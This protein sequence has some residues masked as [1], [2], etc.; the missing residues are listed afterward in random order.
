MEKK[1]FYKKAAII[2]LAVVISFFA[3]ASSL[4]FCLDFPQRYS[5]IDSD[6]RLSWL[7]KRLSSLPSPQEMIGSN[8]IEFIG[9]WGLVTYSMAS[10]ALTNIAM[11]ESERAMEYS[12]HIARWIEWSLLPSAYQFDEEAWGESPLS[13]IVLEGDEG[14]IGYY[15]HL[16]FILGCYALLNDD[17]RF[18]AIHYRISEA[19]ARRMK[20]Y[21]HRHVETYPSQNYPPDNSVAVASLRFYDMVANTSKYSSLIEEWIQETKKIEAGPYGLVVFQIDTATGMPVQKAR[22][23][24]NAWNSFYLAFIDEDYARIQYKKMGLMIRSA[25]GFSALREYAQ[26]HNFTGD[27]DTGPV[28]FGLGAS[29]TAF[30]IG[31]ATRW[32][33]FDLRKRLLRSIELFGCS[34]THGNMRHYAAAPVV[35]EAILLAMKT[36][37]PWRKL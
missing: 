17:D 26:G 11:S 18:S 29:S 6:L 25:V 37:R 19:I 4:H 15:G 23:S 33:D 10:A 27:R 28:I 22:G 9:E 13:D 34:V 32:D 8:N 31:G 14:H 35:G 16:N 5:S 24:N 1:R 2:F 21:P 30:L 3:S 36:A 20:K 7:I 12:E